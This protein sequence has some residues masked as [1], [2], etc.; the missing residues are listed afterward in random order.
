M[1]FRFTI[2]QFDY[3]TDSPQDYLILTWH[4][5]YAVKCW[6]F[7]Y[8][9]QTYMIKNRSIIGAY[10]FVM[11]IDKCSNLKSKIR[12]YFSEQ[13]Y[14]YCTAT[15]FKKMFRKIIPEAKT[16]QTFAHLVAYKIQI[17]T[18]I[19]VQA[20]KSYNLMVLDCIES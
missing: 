10:T 5:E 7:N 8:H 17:E 6:S 20:L 1:R 16:E 14:T 9:C 13:L 19:P 4:Q 18:D 2:V 15:E 11:Q 12:N 3:P